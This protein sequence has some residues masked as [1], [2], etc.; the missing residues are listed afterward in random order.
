MIIVRLE[1]YILFV[2]QIFYYNKSVKHLIYQLNIFIKFNM[3]CISKFNN[4]FLLE[5]LLVNNIYIYIYIYIYSL[6]SDI[7]YSSINH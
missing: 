5:L 2:H 1:N 6:I 4:L 3:K 7:K